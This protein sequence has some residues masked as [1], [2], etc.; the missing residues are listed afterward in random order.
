MSITLSGRKVWGTVYK[1]YGD[2]NWKEKMKELLNDQDTVIVEG[3]YG[4]GNLDFDYNIKGYAFS[5]IKK[6]DFIE[7]LEKINIGYGDD[8]YLYNAFENTFNI[9]IRR[10]KY[11]I[12]SANRYIFVSHI[13]TDCQML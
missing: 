6:E 13:A 8:V 2:K 5:V 10:E 1:D 4:S 3:R 11:P 7:K 12:T 9:H